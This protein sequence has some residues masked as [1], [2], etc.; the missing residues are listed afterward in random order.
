MF[1][2]W[3]RHDAIQRSFAVAT[4]T[5]PTMF[6]PR[7]P[8]RFCVVVSTGQAM[9]VN[10]DITAEPSPK[11]T[12]CVT[13]GYSTIIV[14]EDEVGGTVCEPVWAWSQSATPGAWMRTY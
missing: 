3:L 4:S 7:D 13:S 11:P 9:N 12:F 10:F 1:K 8:M 14:T 6:I 5:T 2:I